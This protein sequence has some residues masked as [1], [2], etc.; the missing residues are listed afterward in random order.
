MDIF[1]FFDAVPY[2]VRI[3]L[4]LFAILAFQKVTKR[5]DLAMLAGI[6]LL[7]VSLRHSAGAIF[8]IAAAR[9]VSRDTLFL[10]LVVAGVIW[11]SGL[12]SRAGIMKDLVVSLKSRLSRR[13][14]LAVLPAVVGLL[15]MPGGALFSCPLLDDADADGVVPPELKTRINHWFRHLWEFWL[16]LYPG[17][18]L[19]IDVSGLPV[20]KLSLLQFPVSMAAVA[21]GAFFLLR[22]APRGAPEKAADAD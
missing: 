20:W 21:A 11:L 13:A 9:I 6:L 14:I 2:L 10:A 22:R 4:S 8:R 16:P 12:M 18:L 17:V 3:L 1:A 15:P 19:A 7:G 5:L